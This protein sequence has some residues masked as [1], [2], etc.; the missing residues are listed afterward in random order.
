MAF[1]V[2][3]QKQGALFLPSFPSSTL[4]STNSAAEL[5]VAVVWDR[6]FIHLWIWLKATWGQA[7]KRDCVTPSS[8]SSPV[9]LSI[10]L[11]FGLKG[12]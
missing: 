4:K 6:R 12:M 2:L 11:A 5:W 7:D 9:H 8:L 10:T 1:Q 3:V